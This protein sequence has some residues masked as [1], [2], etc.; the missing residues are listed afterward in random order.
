MKDANVC[1]K[2]ETKIDGQCPKGT[3]KT[4]MEVKEWIRKF[5]DE[6]QHGNTTVDVTDDGILIT[7]THCMC[8]AYK[9]V[10]G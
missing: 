10:K 6:H 8:Q 4:A 2:G 5:Q 7:N 1:K 9:I 3:M